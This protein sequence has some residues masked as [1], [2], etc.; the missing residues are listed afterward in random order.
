MEIEGKERGVVERKS[1]K[2][3]GMQGKCTQGK[4]L[5]GS[6]FFQYVAKYS[7]NVGLSASDINPQ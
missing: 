4:K 1:G 3:E 5:Q 6:P 7:V 2:E